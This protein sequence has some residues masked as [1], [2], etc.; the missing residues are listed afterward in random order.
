MVTKLA[1]P[2]F[3]DDA[4]RQFLLGQL[5]EETRATFE[6]ALFFN[7]SLEQRTR[8]AELALAD[9]YAQGTLRAKELNA[10]VKNFPVS[11]ARVR[12]IEVSMALRERY[13]ATSP[14]V[15][16]QTIASFAHPV[17]KWAFATM[18][19]IM[20]FATIWLATKQPRLVQRFVPHR[21]RPTAVA[22][23]TPQVAHHAERASEPR[24]HQ[25]QQTPA[26]GHE[27]SSELV[28]LDSTQTAENARAITLATV[29]DK[30][31]HVQLVL[32]EDAQSSYFAE[33]VNS[34]GEV[35]FSEAAVAIDANARR[36]NFDIP[37]E[38][39]A[40]GDF[41]IRLTRTSDGKQTSYFFRVK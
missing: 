26:P 5:R 6:F 1:Q 19:L 18:I 39:L 21:N 22:M 12:Q 17:W 23:P 9:E 2:Q 24:T 37:I 28:V 8:L 38:Q 25:D 20:L 34:N 16:G 11:A 27:F 32:S 30:S 15:S 40:A 14:S 41:Q 10:F 29:R 4:V 3:S 31:V 36:V 33:L 13:A 35:V 7:R